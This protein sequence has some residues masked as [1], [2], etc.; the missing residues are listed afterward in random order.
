MAASIETFKSRLQQLVA[1]FDSDRAHYLSKGYLEAQARTDFITPFFE[2]LGWD[3]SNK[4]GLRHDVREVIVEK[5]ES[6]TTGRPDYSFRTEGK[7]KFFVEA[8]APSETL[9]AIKHV[10]QAKTYA[11]NTSQVF[12]VVLTDFAEF[13]FYD[14]SIRPDDR[15]PDEG[16][17]LRLDYH[18][19]LQNAQKLWEFSR[20]RVSSG[21]LD[22][23]LSRDLRTKRL[24]IPV[25]QAFLD[26]MTGWREDLAKDI[27]KNNPDLRVRQLNE[28]VQRLL[29]RIVFIRIAEDRRIIEK[30]QLADAVDEWKARRGKF[31]ISEWLS[32]LFQRIN[33]D[34]NGEIFKPHLADDVKVDSEVLAHIIERLY[35]PKSPYRF[36]VIGVELLGSIYER[37]LGNTI[38]L[39]AKQVRVEEKPELRKA[40]GIYYTPKY[41]VDYIVRNTVAMLIQGKTPKQIERLCILDPACG[42]GSFLIGAFQCLIDYHTDWYLD[43]PEPERRHGRQP[44]EFMRDVQ[45][46]ADGT[47]HLSV[48][49][50]VKILT[51]NLFGVDIDPQAT[52]ITMMSLYLKALEG[53][54]QQLP[55]KQSL[56]PPLKDNIICGNSL[57]GPEFNRNRQRSLID[58]DEDARINVFDWQAQFGDILK[59][60]GFDAVIGNPPYR[61]ELNYK[62]LM[63]E[64]A[65]TP[66]GL[67]YRSPRMDLWYY[68]VHRGLEVL[69]PSGVL[70]FIVNAYW[71]SGTGAEKLITALRDTAHIDEIFS[72]GGLAVFQRVSG[73]HMILRVTKRGSRAATL[74]KLA[75]PTSERTAE[76]FVEGKASVISFSKKADE[77][78]RGGTIDIQPDSGGLLEKFD[79]GTPLCELGKI[80]QGIAENPASINR[81]TNLRYKGRFEV[82]EGVFT[83][84]PEEFESLSLPAKE[85]TLLRPYHDL[86]DIGRYRLSDASLWLIYSTPSTTV[87]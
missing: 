11:W 66:F 53:E 39:T 56:L 76:P 32:G 72:F 41:V 38:R 34:F 28:V 12:F 22:A 80:R 21:S 64:I 27:Y 83:L 42:S 37:Y 81:K 71:V 14:A 49:R 40:G 58:E 67:K 55:S 5:G 79:Q 25:D 57:I 47:H 61:R 46:D 63:D 2:A 73:S 3:V 10:L 52:E 60:G 85:R 13:R 24:R 45:T 74:I 17:L 69:R 6:D 16:L 62:N 36:D 77:L 68:F 26:E 48:Y 35:P 18:D 70:S 65:S 29:D 8:K 84:R 20:D 54:R 33:E 78:F 9:S 86:S 50:K 19:Y 51:N 15:N 7:G 59:A 1:N 4:Q 75:N 23:L 31:H 82:G 43:H 30:R 87:L 44:L